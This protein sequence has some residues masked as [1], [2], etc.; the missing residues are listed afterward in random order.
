M[1]LIAVILLQAFFNFY[2]EY[3]SDCVMD[4]LNAMLPAR[5]MTIRGG[6]TLQIPVS[7]LVVGDII[8]LGGGEKVPAD[9]R[10]I[11]VKDMKID[12][13]TL[14]GES[15]PVRCAID[16][17][18]R[19]IMQTRNVAF[20]GCNVTEGTG[21]G[22]V[23]ATG[24]RTIFGEIA[25]LAATQKP[26]QSTLHREI[27]RFVM[28]IVTLAVTTG[29]V[30]LA[31]WYF[32]LHQD[33]PEFLKFEAQIVNCISLIVAFVPEGMPICV[34]V[35]LA[36]IA[37]D[38]SK[39][40]VLVKNLATVETLGA[41]SVIASDKTGTLTE[42]K[43]TV[44]ELSC[45]TNG[46]EHDELLD[47]IAL[48][49]RASRQQT[50]T[51]DTLIVGDASDSALLRH[52][53]V[54]SEAV[55]KPAADALRSEWP[56][57]AELPFNST[58]KY[59]LSIHHIPGCRDKLLLMKGSPERLLERC[60]T[61]MSGGV[62]R[63]LSPE[64]RSSLSRSIT[65]AASRGQRILGF[66]SRK[67]ERKD[68]GDEYVF[69][70]DDFNFP[71]KDL[72]FMG[73]VALRDP[74]RVGVAEA[75]R[76]LRGA[77][78][79]VAMVTGDMRETAQAIARHVGIIQAGTVHNYEQLQR[80][81]WAAASQAAVILTG[82]EIERLDPLGWERVCTYREAVF[83]RTT[84]KQKLEIV[85]AF[86]ARG[87][88]VAVTGDGVNDS[89]ALR[90]A[91]CGIAMGSGS[92][93]S[94]EAAD[95]IILD[96]RFTNVVLGVQ[97][98]RRCFANLKK[99]IIYLLPA[100]SWSEMLPVM[101]NVFLGMPLALSSFLMIVIC[102]CTD[103]G[104][105]LAMVYEKPE[106]SIMRAPPR[107]IGKD[108]LVTGKL[109]L[110]AYL[111]IGMIEAAV[112]YATFFAY[113]ACQGLYPSDL[114]FKFGATPDGTSTGQCFYF[115]ALVVM[116]F[117]NALTS[118]TAKIPAFR[119]SAFVGSTKNLRFL[120][121]FMVSAIVFFVTCYVP[122]IQKGLSTTGL[123]ANWQ[124]LLIPWMGAAVLV[125]SNE[126]R[127]FIAERYPGGL[128]ARMLWE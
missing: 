7:D 98:G 92:E 28:V 67:L 11:N 2:Q 124:P 46:R 115:Y 61:W 102:C 37:K 117:G 107:R 116:Q 25:R 29:L 95:L 110:N 123:T 3:K 114:L 113:F 21:T 15:E 105:S 101:T 66:C 77:H 121:A 69:D 53:M 24:D 10:L 78:I 70:V 34:T 57:V 89:P 56:K 13:S 122:F 23:I 108:H 22:I 73:W 84:P 118:R 74:P 49:N 33:H 27:Q 14:N 43:M 79:R 55:G 48:C 94:K 47:A 41:V 26:E 88:C 96:D 18:D 59:M 20:F 63:H 106:S 87:E 32:W 65:D 112:A 68:F 127:K 12:K 64:D 62:E 44:S 4:V 8:T 31:G 93:V 60:N 83:A 75:V 17:S 5:A 103:V 72:L 111:F 36:L 9:I 51:G 104:P 126:A 85:K 42:N 119:H 71:T 40:Q 99:V 58:N 19:N 45:G 97:H 50:P 80:H 82:P 39:N 6:V 90:Q 125:C 100:G 52:Y 86:Q 91:D 109:I 30:A 1:V 35:T 120:L 76:S 16:Y 128:V 54:T 81:D 38:M